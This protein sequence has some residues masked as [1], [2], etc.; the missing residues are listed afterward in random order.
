MCHYLAAGGDKIAYMMTQSEYKTALG[1]LALTQEEVAALLGTNKRT[2][3][4][5]ASGESPVPRPIEM[6]IRL[7]VK[8]PEL[9]QLVRELAAER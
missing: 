6:H 7:W 1:Q 5:W 2:A 3:R 4:R 8:R 9:I